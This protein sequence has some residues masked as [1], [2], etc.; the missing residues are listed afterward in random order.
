MPNEQ[1]RDWRGVEQLH[2][3]LRDR[4]AV[5]LTNVDIPPA[6]SGGSRY[7]EYWAVATRIV[8]VDVTWD[9]DPDGI[10]RASWDVFVPVSDSHKIDATLED[11]SA[12]IEK[13]HT[14]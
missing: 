6:A 12:W 5:Q 1:K 4:N 14:T 13:V 7:I 3:T 9:E 11:L 2:K 10:Q 8:L